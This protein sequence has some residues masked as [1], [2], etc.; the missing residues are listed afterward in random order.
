MELRKLSDKGV[1]QFRTYLQQLAEGSTAGAPLQLLT[2]P[3][4]SR[5][6]QEHVPLEGKRFAARLELARYLDNALGNLH[7]RP[8]VI[9]NDVNLWS[10]L[11]LFYFDQVCPVDERGRRKPGRDYRH[12]PEPGYPYGHRHL[13]LGAYLVYTVCGWGDELSRLPLHTALSVESNFHHEIAGRQN[14]ITNRGI[15]EAMHI[16]YFDD[17]HDRPKRGPI[18]NKKAP[19]SLNRFINVIQQLD[20][21]YDLYSMSGSEIVS[22]LPVEFTPWRDKQLKLHPPP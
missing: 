15:M 19:G 10:W 8:D 4:S 13:L 5:P 17:A 11:S 12:I 2:D 22:L 6:T 14:F 16:L 7:D 21:T 20:V 18:M 9:A 3:D 1:E